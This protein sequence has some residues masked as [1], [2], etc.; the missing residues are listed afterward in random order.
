MPST[1]D[2]LTSATL[3]HLR[4]SWWDDEFTEFLAETL[5]PRPG[6]RILDVGC[7]EGQAEV[8]IGR[9]HVSQLQLAGVDRAA[10]K[11][12]AARREAAS[13]NLRA[14]FTAGDACRL[15]FRDGIFD[16]TYC[17][18]V[19]QHIKDVDAAVRE[20]ARVTAG[21][22]RIVVVEPD[23]AGR[24]FYSST[25]WGR[26]AAQVAAQFFASLSA[27]RGDGTDPAIGPKIPAIF[28][29]YGIEPIE[30]RMFPVSQTQLGVPAEDA[31]QARRQRLERAVAEAATDDVKALGREYLVLFDAYQSEAKQAGSGFIE[32]QNTMLFA[33]VGQKP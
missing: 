23:N 17:V 11:V 21:G 27:A 13:H 19:L 22:G 15:P 1:M 14:W 31:W 32:I 3:K 24:Y 12:A 7:G 10:D 30:V 2:H 4:E 26:R 9:L 6:N 5:R 8:A 33:T 28:A 25:P 16:S 18:A 29:R 20:F